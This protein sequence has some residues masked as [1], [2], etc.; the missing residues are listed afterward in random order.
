M[1]FERHL[2]VLLVTAWITT[3]ASASSCFH[4][5]TDDDD[6]GGGGRRQRIRVKDASVVTTKPRSRLVETG[7][8]YKLSM[9]IPGVEPKDLD[10]DL[11]WNQRKITLMGSRRVDKEEE[12]LS[13]SYSSSSAAA[14]V[15]EVYH[16]TWYVDTSVQMEDLVMEYRN[17]VVVVCVP[18]PHNEQVTEPKISITTIRPP[19]IKKTTTAAAAAGGVRGALTEASK[20]ALEKCQQ[21]KNQ[22]EELLD[23]DEINY[24]LHRM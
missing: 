12:V 21:H 24:W 5:W 1:K 8:A 19:S 22:F 10:V 3:I 23:E 15:D 7:T 9:D 13:S 17:G 14:V 18:K 2:L 16:Q 20:D 11:D 6:N 4:P